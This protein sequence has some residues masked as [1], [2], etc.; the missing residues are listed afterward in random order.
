MRKYDLPS[1]SLIQ[2]L[3]DS[4]SSFYSTGI[5]GKR[6]FAKTRVCEISAFIV[7]S[8]L[9]VSVLFP[10]CSSA[11]G[12]NGLGTNTLQPAGSASMNQTISGLV[13]A[14]QFQRIL[15]VGLAFIVGSLG[16]G[17]FFYGVFCGFISKST[18]QSLLEYL[19]DS[20]SGKMKGAILVFCSFG[21]VVAAVFQAPQA[22]FFAPIQAFV[23]GATWP[24]V[25]TQMMSGNSQPPGLVALANA[26]ASQIPV[27]KTGGTATATDAEVVIKPKP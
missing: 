5:K 17:A 19:V 2:P 21:G 3:L 15:N 8:L 1:V 25:V 24:S 12:T 6:L 7:V 14:D 18:R 4:L 11:Q 9:L 20:N 26:P 22:S 27:P 23:L 13:K 16:A 10:E